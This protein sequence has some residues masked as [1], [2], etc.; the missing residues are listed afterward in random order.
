VP[1]NSDETA[2]RFRVWLSVDSQP[3]MLLWDRKIEGGFPELKV[4]VSFWTYKPICELNQG[5][6]NAF[7][8]KCSQ[9]SRWGIQIK[10]LEVMVLRILYVPLYDR[11]L[12]W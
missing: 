10:K 2:G 12:L 3:P 5:R 7:V 9:E 8:I 6:S 4:L 1:R 11:Y